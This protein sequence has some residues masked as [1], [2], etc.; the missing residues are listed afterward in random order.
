MVALLLGVVRNIFQ[1]EFPPCIQV[2]AFLDRGVDSTVLLFDK[3]PDPPSQFPITRFRLQNVCQRL[4]KLDRNDLPK[5][6]LDSLMFAKPI[7]QRAI[8]VI[9]EHRKVHQFRSDSHLQTEQGLGHLLV[10]YI[11][12]RTL[13]QNTLVYVPN[14]SKES[15]CHSVFLHWTWKYQSN[16]WFGH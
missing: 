5:F 2:G 7:K 12:T 15:I 9:L 6:C 8:A 13:R 10:I 4:L 11:D 3:V 1:T 14:L 16:V